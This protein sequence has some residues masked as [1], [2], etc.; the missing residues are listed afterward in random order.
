MF[1]IL[2]YQSLL[3]ALELNVPSAAMKRW[4][5]VPFSAESHPSVR[6]HTPSVPFVNFTTTHLT[7]VPSRTWNSAVIEVAT[8]NSFVSTNL[9][10]SRAVVPSTVLVTVL[11]QN[12][13]ERS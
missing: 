7:V 11:P 2:P 13:A 8:P 6:A 1:A 5:S 4:P 3:A 9:L 10:Y 12:L